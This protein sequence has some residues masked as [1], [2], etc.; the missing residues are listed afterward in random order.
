MK[1][2][3]FITSYWPQATETFIKAEYLY[4]K[5]TVDLHA[6]CVFPQENDPDVKALFPLKPQ[7][8]YK[9]SFIKS[10]IKSIIPSKMIQEKKYQISI[11][12]LSTYC[13]SNNI[14]HIYAA[15]GDISSWLA[16]KTSNITKIPFSVSLHADDYFNSTLFSKDLLISAKHVFVCNKE[17]SNQIK[18]DYPSIS[19]LL[20]FSHGVDLDLFD[21]KLR[22]SNLNCLRLL[23]IGR[24]VAKKGIHK[25]IELH[26]YLTDHHIKHQ[27]SIYGEGP[28]RAELAKYQSQNFK[29]FSSVP[30]QSVKGILQNHDLFVF[31]SIAYPKS[32]EGLSNIV[33]ESMA[34]GTTVALS[35]SGGLKELPPK[36]YIDLEEFSIFERINQEIL[37]KKSMEARTLIEHKFNKKELLIKKFHILVGKK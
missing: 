29:L 3:L 14:E 35:P 6:F 27:F 31:P 8:A 18:L 13:E 17:T 12:R 4:L 25:L 34:A 30:H 26:K 20:Y 33:L 10:L 24:F 32:R 5:R 23:F 37:S 36:T 7:N 1:R 28:L 21:F 15:T 9:N 2:I 19:N 11:D 22:E 16:F